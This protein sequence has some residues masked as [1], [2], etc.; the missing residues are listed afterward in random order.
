LGIDGGKLLA[1]T[2]RL[3]LLEK[4]VDCSGDLRA[5]FDDGELLCRKIG[6]VLKTQ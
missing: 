5:D 1:Q 4:L 6:D 3:L 2:E